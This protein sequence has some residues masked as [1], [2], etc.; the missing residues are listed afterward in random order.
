M[1]FVPKCR[2]SKKAICPLGLNE[3]RNNWGHSSLQDFD[4]ETFRD[5]LDSM[6]LLAHSELLWAVLCFL[7][8]F[9]LFE[10]F[11]TF[12]AFSGRSWAFSS[13]LSFFGL[14]ALSETCKNTSVYAGVQ[15]SGLQMKASGGLKYSV[16]DAFHKK[17]VVFSC[18]FAI[19][20]AWIWPCRYWG[21]K[22]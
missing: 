6:R 21:S 5:F 15:L 14:E 18:V 10:P 3:C 16:F 22:G 8:Q 13:F 12:C 2:L 17:I 19:F 1:N 20:H 9:G 4:F 7:S 11:P